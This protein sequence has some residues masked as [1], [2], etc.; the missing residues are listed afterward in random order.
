MAYKL[1]SKIK[2]AWIKALRSG[3]YKQCK[4][5]LKDSATGS[6]CCLGVLAEVT[7]KI[8][9]TDYDRYRDGANSSLPNWLLIEA[10]FREKHLYRSGVFDDPWHVKVR[11][12]KNGE[13]PGQTSLYQL[14]DGY[15]Y[16]FD[17]IADVIERYF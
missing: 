9:E 6:Y 3:E 17:E 2:K 12:E 7:A 14:N 11:E 4:R 1:R 15:G 16:T 13:T 10:V 5:K 8:E